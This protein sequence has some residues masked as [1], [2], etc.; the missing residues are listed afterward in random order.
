[1]VIMPRAKFQYGQEV[2]IQADDFTAD[3]HPEAEVITTPKFDIND[4]Y[5]PNLTFTIGHWCRPQSRPA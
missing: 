4:A 1:M 3:L 5:T 2:N